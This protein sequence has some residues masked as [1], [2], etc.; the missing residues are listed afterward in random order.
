MD[1]ED[2][3]IFL[4]NKIIEAES[5]HVPESWKEFNKEWIRGYY[6][7]LKILEDNPKNG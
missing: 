3:K 6:R 5:R 4:I 2:K 7:M 1:D